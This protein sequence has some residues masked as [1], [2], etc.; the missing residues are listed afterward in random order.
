MAAWMLHGVCV[1]EE[2]RAGNRT[3]KYFV[4]AFRFAVQCSTGKY[5]VQALLCEVVLEGG[6]CKLSSTKSYWEV[7]QH[8][9]FFALAPRSG[10]GAAISVVIVCAE[11]CLCASS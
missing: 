4:H 8:R 11:A 6:L 1:G 10:F 9:I 3:G 5:F 7:L 2:A